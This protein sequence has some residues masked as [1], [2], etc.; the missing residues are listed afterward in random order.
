[1][2]SAFDTRRP[3]VTSDKCDLGAGLR[4]NKNAAFKQR[5]TN[6]LGQTW[7]QNRALG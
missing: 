1:V 6:G 5:L 4:G 2:V 7:S 3:A